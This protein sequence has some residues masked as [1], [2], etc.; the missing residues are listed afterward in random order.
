M[1]GAN[2]IEQNVCTFA[3]SPYIVD[4]EQ[5]EAKEFPHMVSG[6]VRHQIAQ[7]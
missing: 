3:V 7:I 6:W 2:R 5:A 4:G 1:F